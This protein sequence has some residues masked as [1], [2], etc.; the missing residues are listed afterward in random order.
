MQDYEL[1]VFGQ[2]GQVGYR[3]AI[4]AVNDED[5]V[6]RITETDMP[7]GAELRRGHVVVAKFGSWRAT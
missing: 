6:R 5:A 2:G 4:A 1:V 7:Y 3:Q